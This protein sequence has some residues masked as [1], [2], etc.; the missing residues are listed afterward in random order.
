MAKRYNDATE[1]ELD[2][3]LTAGDINL[4]LRIADAVISDALAKGV[5]VI[6]DARST[7][8]LDPP[9]TLTDDNGGHHDA[10]NAQAR[11]AVP[12]LQGNRRLRNAR[13]VPASPV[14]QEGQVMTKKHFIALA[15]KFRQ[16]KPYVPVEGD[17]LTGQ[18]R[19]DRKVKLAQWHI[20]LVSVADVCAGNSTAFNRV[21]FYTASGAEDT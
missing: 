8:E 15:E 16:S 2:D 13:P 19:R 4:A 5:E 18:E 10:H 9:H 6:P 11:R 21:R 7:Y 20:D 17:G 3:A 14:D 1:R 12:D